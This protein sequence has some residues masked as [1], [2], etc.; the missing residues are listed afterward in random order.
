MIL[1][2]AAW[3]AACI[4]AAQVSSGGSFSLE[5]SGVGPGGA[6]SG[7]NFE[8][9]GFVEGMTG[10][11][12]TDSLKLGGGAFELRVGVMNPPPYLL[13]ASSPTVVALAGGLVTMS[14]PA[15]AV[16][17]PG[18]D[19]V[20]RQDPASNPLTVDPNALLRASNKLAI[21]DPLSLV[22]VQNVFEFKVLSDQ[23]YYEA[24]FAAP[25]LVTFNYTDAD[26]DGVLDG[27]NPPVR[28]KLLNVWTLDESAAQW[29]RVPGVTV[30]AVA[31]SVSA[32]VR[33][34]SVYAFAA[35]S[36]QDVEGVYAFPVPFRPH[37]PEAGLVAGQT[38]TDAGGITFV[39]LPTEGSIEIYTLSGQLVRRLDIPAALPV[40]KLVWDVRN[41]VGKAVVSGVY[42][43]KVASKTA[44][45]TGRLM[46]I[47]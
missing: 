21:N 29:I 16:P 40:P 37:G 42:I 6:A 25:I 41:L 19:L 44:H 11:Q 36:D 35:A 33:H 4:A 12:L 43:W 7:G 24:Q 1:A 15:G 13:N 8:G 22:Q 14:A 45:K 46:V 2:A 39:N 3:L 10:S 28:A 27:T 23:G 47:R 20:V 34:F 18:S 30:D 32:P 17:L 38:G 9:R 5:R 31:R 26:G